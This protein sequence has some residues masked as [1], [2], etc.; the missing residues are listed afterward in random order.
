MHSSRPQL[1]TVLCTLLF[2]GGCQLPPPAPVSE[3]RQA[4]TPEAALA[5]RLGQAQIQLRAQAQAQPQTSGIYAIKD[6]QEAFAARGLLARAAEQ[7]LDVQYYIWRHDKTGL[8]LLHEL[9]MAADR[10]VRV[11]LLL[12]DGGTAGLDAQLH[13]LSTHPH[14]EVRLF[15]PFVLRNWLKPLGYVTEFSRTNRR[16]HNKSFSADGQASIVGGRNVGNEYFGATDGVLF[17]DL[18]VLALGPVV[19]DI[20]EDFDR[21]WNNVAAYPAELIARPDPAMDLNALRTAGQTLAQSPAAQDYQQALQAT[22]MVQHL[23]QAQLPMEWA[24]AHL[25]S[26]PPEKIQAE[27]DKQ[28]L[29]GEQLRRALGTPTQSLDLVSPYFVPTQAGVQAFAELR[30]Q[31]LHVR[32]LTNALEATDVA[33]VHSGYAKYRKPLL[34][35]GVQLYEMRRHAPDAAQA[36]KPFKLTELGSSGSSLHAKTFAVDGQRVFVGSFNFDPRSMQLNTEMGLMIESPALTQQI[37]HSFEQLIPSHSYRVSLTDQ[38]QLRWR[39]GTG[40]ATTEYL[41]EPKS[42]WYQRWMLRFLGWLPI[43]WL[44]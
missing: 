3:M 17:A 12:D 33:I 14:I 44:L 27:A 15:N 34:Q 21:Y 37:S 19:Q 11:R 43:E 41:I 40:A 18:D 8:L 6:P 10:G 28:T 20:E 29:I 38:G 24:V 30:Q 25:V 5:T 31:G 39:T 16:M 13:A 2:L 36:T 4:I 7:T 42:T 1:A 35:E 26:D 32:I 22:P 9:L 23:L